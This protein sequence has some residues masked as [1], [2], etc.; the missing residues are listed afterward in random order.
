MT[1]DFGNYNITGK[2]VEPD[3]TK[4]NT[5]LSNISSA[6]KKVIDGQWVKAFHLYW[7]NEDLTNTTDG[8]IMH[9]IDMSNYLPDDNYFYEVRLQFWINA[10]LP[11]ALGHQELRCFLA[12]N[13]INNSFS[14]FYLGSAFA[15]K[16]TDFNFANPIVGNVIAVV[17]PER[18]IKIG[19]YKN[20]YGK[21]VDLSQVEYRRIGTND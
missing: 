11:S 13:S 4:L 10:T 7:D 16:M 18:K 8:N 3:S 14:T 15:L 21:C 20:S 2:N 19:V 1:L 9:E 17:S 12:H 5:D 6:G